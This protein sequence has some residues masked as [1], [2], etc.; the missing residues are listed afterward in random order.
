MKKLM[1]IAAIGFGGLG[2]SSV[3][4]AQQTYSGY[5]YLYGSRPTYYRY[6]YRP[7]YYDYRLNVP[8]IVITINRTPS[9]PAPSTALAIPSPSSSTFRPITPAP[10]FPS[11]ITSFRPVMPAPASA[12]PAPLPAPGGIARGGN[13]TPQPF[14]ATPVRN[15]SQTGVFGTQGP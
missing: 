1:L 6:G 10:A 15:G 4:Q 2:L 3:A 12:F 7:A 13:Q 5:G 14:A 9:W 8:S 11:P